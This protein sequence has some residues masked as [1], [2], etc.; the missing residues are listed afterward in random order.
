MRKNYAEKAPKP[1]SSQY[2]NLVKMISHNAKLRKLSLPKGGVVPY[3]P[4]L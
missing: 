4:L 2:I 1:A 3:L